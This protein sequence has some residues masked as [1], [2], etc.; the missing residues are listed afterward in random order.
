MQTLAINIKDKNT[1]EKFLWLL[2]HFD[3]NEIEIIKEE[4]LQDLKL[5]AATRDEEIVPYEDY[6]KNHNKRI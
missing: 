3:K 1:S 4:D 5:L 2:K 6:L